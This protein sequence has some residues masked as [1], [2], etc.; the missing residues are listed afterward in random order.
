MPF[1]EVENS[2]RGA[3]FMRKDS[4]SLGHIEFHVPVRYPNKD[5]KGAVRDTDMKPNGQV[6]AEIQ[7]ASSA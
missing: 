3:G 1:A 6:W 5:I 2:G 7:M 4:F